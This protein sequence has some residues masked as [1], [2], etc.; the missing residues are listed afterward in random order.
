MAAE[1][2]PAA[3]HVLPGS[4]ASMRAPVAPLGPDAVLLAEDLYGPAAHQQGMYEAAAAREAGEQCK[5]WEE[6]SRINE[7]ITLLAWQTHLEQLIQELLPRPGG[8]GHR[9]LLNERSMSSDSVKTLSN[10]IMVVCCYK[11][12]KGT[13][14]GVARKIAFM[15]ACSGSRRMAAGPAAS[16]SAAATARAATTSTRTTA[17]TSGTTAP[18]WW[19]RGSARRATT[20][21]PSA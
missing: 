3:Q 21:S 6:L 20:P 8:L 4:S 10:M 5:H 1:A 13:M 15:H 18:S 12:A 11:P 14:T 17:A 16:P 19:T 7:T 2:A 9:R